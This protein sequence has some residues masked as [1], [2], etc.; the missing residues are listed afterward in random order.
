MTQ[1]QYVVVK[2]KIEG[3]IRCLGVHRRNKLIQWIKGIVNEFL[4]EITLVLSHNE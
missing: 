4:E 3:T 1:L 2:V